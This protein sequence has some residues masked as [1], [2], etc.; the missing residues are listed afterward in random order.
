MWIDSILTRFS[1]QP[2]QCYTPRFYQ[3]ASYAGLWIV[4]YVIGFPLF[5]LWKLWT[6]KRKLLAGTKQLH[7]LR[8]E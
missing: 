7:E 3:M 5:V 6:Y 1:I 8:C 4:G 2:C